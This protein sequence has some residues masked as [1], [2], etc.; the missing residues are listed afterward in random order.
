MSQER[1][2]YVPLGGAGEIGMNMYA[3]G[4]GRPGKERFILVD[5]GVTFPSMDGTPGVDLITAD[6]GWIADQAD[7]IDGIIITHAHE[8]HIGALGMLYDRLSAPVYCRRFTALVAESK[9]DAWNR[10]TSV[11]RVL[12]PYPEMTKIGPF[13][14]GIM[15]VPHSIPEAS[16]LVIDTPVGRVVHTGDLKLD[17]DPIV[18]EPFDP[19]FFKSIAQDGVKALVCDSTNVFSP[20]PGRSEA[21]LRAP[22]RD[23]V[24]SAHGLV[25]ATTFASN[26]ARLKT[27]AQAGEEA[28]RSVCVLG[29]SMQR[30]MGYARDAEV[31][32]SFPPIVAL[33]DAQ[34]IPRSNLMLIVT[35]SQGE[36]RAASAQLASG[37]YLGFEMKEGDMFLFSSKTIPGNEV[38]VARVINALAEQGVRV[39]DDSTP[40]YHVSG[41]ANRPD[42]SKVHELFK[43]EMLIP[44]HGEYRHLVEHARLAT[45]NDLPS[46]VVPNGAVADLTGDVPEVVDNVET[47][48]L[49]LDGHELIGAFDGVVLERVRMA[50]RGMVAASVILEGDDL[51]GVWV[52]ALGLPDPK[53]VDNEL[54][55]ILESDLE[56]EVELTPV[57]TRRNDDT[58][59]ERLERRIAHSTN[60]LVGKKPVVRVLLNRLE[61]D[62]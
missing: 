6:P 14:V 38:G 7:R 41:H 32:G 28:G 61:D 25:V 17:A 52:E 13:T 42:L 26:I 60:D 9:L 20:H 27:L 1:L 40:E 58:L 30:M 54:A 23:L 16:G 47:G 57:K 4:W 3:Y 33:E 31:L 39:I 18:G 50:T 29:R 10:D 34:D 43:P 55:V 21:E 5:L 11:V 56:D 49:Y 22:I 53:R 37:K 19:D 12:A 35:G 36:R 15:P 24:V 51:V 8:D 62:A 59:I 2:I 44:M 48:R 45:S 46:L